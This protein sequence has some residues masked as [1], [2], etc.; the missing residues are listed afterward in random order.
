MNFLDVVRYCLDNEELVEQFNRLNKNKLGVDN[1]S[2]I[3]KM[4]DEACEYDPND[5]AMTDFLNFVYVAVWQ[6]MKSQELKRERK[7]IYGV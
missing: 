5:E 4:I 2:A 7:F 6:P 1:R 3:A